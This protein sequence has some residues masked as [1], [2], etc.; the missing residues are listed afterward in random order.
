MPD[1][2]RALHHTAQRW[3]VGLPTSLLMLLRNCST[4]AL[5]PAGQG[6][7]Q[8]PLQ[9]SQVAAPS[10][11]KQHRV[12][13]PCL[14]CCGLNHDGGTTAA[15]R[16]H[17]TRWQ[18]ASLQ[19]SWPPSPPAPPRTW[20][21]TR[22]SHSRR[23]RRPRHGLTRKSIRV[24]CARRGRVRGARSARELCAAWEGAGRAVGVVGTGCAECA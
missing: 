17:R 1:L 22:G 15:C 4:A 18:Q 7:R 3:G 19:R 16:L 11:E 24:S 13:A 14:I 6:R 20:R 12:A 21:R 2:M 23:R 10:T 5:L 8:Q 9:H